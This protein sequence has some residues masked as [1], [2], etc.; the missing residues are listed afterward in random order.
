MKTK[1]LIFSN[2]LG[3][4]PEGVAVVVGVG[5]GLV[6]AVGLIG[7]DIVA[8]GVDEIVEGRGGVVAGAKEGDGVGW[9]L[10]V[11]ASNPRPAARIAG[12]S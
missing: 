11:Q 2:P 7:V 1:C 3:T 6:V 9:T 4:L 12:M 8:G 5:L 10:E